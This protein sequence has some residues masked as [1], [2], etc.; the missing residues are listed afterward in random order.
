MRQP[1]VQLNV[2]QINDNPFDNI[3]KLLYASP[4]EEASTS[5]TIIA[6]QRDNIQVGDMMEISKLVS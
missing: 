2:F 3:M 5:L 4:C 1:C 6:A